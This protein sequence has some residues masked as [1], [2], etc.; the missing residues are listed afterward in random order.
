MYPHFLP[1]LIQLT[2][3]KATGREVNRRRSCVA[4]LVV[5]LRADDIP[6][7]CHRTGAPSVRLIWTDRPSY[8]VSPGSNLPVVCRG[9]GSDGGGYVLQC[10]TWGLIPSFTR[11]TEKP[12]FYKMFN[13]RSESVGEK[14]SFRRLLPKSR[15]LVAVEGMAGI[16]EFFWKL[17]WFILNLC[18]QYSN[19]GEILYTFTIL[20]TSSSSALQWLHDRMPVILGNKEAVDTWLNGSSSSK[21]DIVLKPYENSDLVW[22]PVTPAMGKTSFDGPECIKEI[23]FK[24]EDQSTISKFFSRKEIKREQESNLQE[25]TCDKAVNIDLRESVKEEH[26]SI[27]KLEIPSLTEKFDDNI[28][29][30]VSIMP[31]EDKD[32]TKCKTKRNH[33]EPLADSNTVKREELQRSPAR[34]KANIKSGVGGDRDKQPTLLSYFSKR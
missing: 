33:E 31:C 7:A 21:F 26:G 16:C 2:K 9:D 8:N 3:K 14:A 34:K 29:S 20:T 10:M 23:H 18:L 32:E 11:K 27:D 13:A 4:E 22:Y 6:R 15:C 12:D 1:A 24:T 25:G 28:K 5:L 30:N 17:S 19:S